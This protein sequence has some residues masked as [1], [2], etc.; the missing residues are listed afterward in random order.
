MTR[1]ALPY[2]E[3]SEDVV[4]C[5]PWRLVLEEGEIDLPPFLPDWDYQMDV[6]LRRKIH[7]DV[8]RAQSEAGLFPGT[9][10]TIAAVWSATGSNLRA[11]GAK[12]V[13]SDPRP[14]DVQL[15]FTIRGTE[16]GGELVLATSL[17][18][19]QAVP[20]AGP[21]APRRAGSVLWNDQHS[22]RLQGDAAQFPVAVID[23]ANT[24]FAEEAAWHLQV[25]ETMYQSTM[26]KLLLLVNEQNEQVTSAF[27][28]A[29]NP[30][31]IDQVVLASVKADVTRTMLE[32]ALCDPEF[33]DD[34]TFPDDTWGMTLKDL[35]DRIFPGRSITDVRLQFQRSPSTFA[36][37]LQA[38]LN[39]LEELS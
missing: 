1:R 36:S 11:P 28:N 22:M 15:D 9:P 7:V 30:S 5:E 13:M 35:F 4:V 27:T 21:A 31:K 38:S 16:L 26:G 3:P 6:T 20:D 8:G 23:F 10:L 19:A 39:A 17:V 2:R 24:S 25:P 29:G 12:V 37:D 34:E 33:C 14:H 18:L 32:H